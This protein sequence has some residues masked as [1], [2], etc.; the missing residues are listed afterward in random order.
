MNPELIY[1]YVRLANE[2]PLLITVFAT[3]ALLNGIG[4]TWYLSDI[5]FTLFRRLQITASQISACF[6]IW[7]LLP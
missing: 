3:I 7:D 1:D 2:V 5:V 6:T 4:G